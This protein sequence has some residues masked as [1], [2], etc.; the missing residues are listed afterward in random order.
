MGQKVFVWNK[1]F[2]RDLADPDKQTD[3]WLAHVSPVLAN[4]NIVTE[5]L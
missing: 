1:T 2:T 5:Y 3:V 4:G